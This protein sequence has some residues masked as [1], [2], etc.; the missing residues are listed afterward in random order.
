MRWYWWILIWLGSCFV[1]AMLTAWWL[2]RSVRISDGLED[3]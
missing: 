3:G 1:L 2:R